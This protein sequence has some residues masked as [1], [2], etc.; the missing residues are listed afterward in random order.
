MGEIKEPLEPLIF[1]HDDIRITIDRREGMPDVTILREHTGVEV[2]IA[3]RAIAKMCATERFVPVN[4][5]GFRWMACE[6]RLAWALERV[7]SGGNNT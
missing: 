1:E 3:K 7:E 2:L 5:A 4:D 6:V